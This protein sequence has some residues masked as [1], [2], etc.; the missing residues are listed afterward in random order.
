MRSRPQG[1]IPNDTQCES[2]CAE[3][4]KTHRAVRGHLGGKDTKIFRRGYVNMP[5]A[6]DREKYSA[7]VCRYYESDFN[8]SSIF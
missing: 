5:S 3:D 8:L 7:E 6:I 2:S 4:R 1:N